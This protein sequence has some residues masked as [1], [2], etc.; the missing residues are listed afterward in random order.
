M[1]WE[2]GEVA[3]RWKGREEMANRQTG[4]V[5]GKLK[6]DLFHSHP[7]NLPTHTHTHSHAHTLTH[8]LTHTYSHAL[9]LGSPARSPFPPPLP[10]HTLLLPT[11]L[12]PHTL[13]LPT[14]LPPHTLLLPPLPTCRRQ[15]SATCK[16]PPSYSS[17]S[18]QRSV[19]P[20]RVV[21]MLPSAKLQVGSC[22]G[23]C[24]AL[25]RLLVSTR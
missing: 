16:P 9:S 24:L 23:V 20:L 5:S 13:P 17:R 19:R 14:P 15:P 8:T 10:L 11:P 22:L 3:E 21:M 4:Y 1:K 12:P 25:S 18:N 6:D 2:E 7:T